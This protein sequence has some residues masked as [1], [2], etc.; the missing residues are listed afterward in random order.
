MFLAQTFDQL[1]DLYDLHRIKSDCRLIQNND[2]RITQNCLC[3]PYSLFIT[4]GKI[5]DQ[6][7]LHGCD[8][9]KLHDFPDLFPSLLFVD[10]LQFCHKCQIFLY[11]HGII[12]RRKLRQIANIPL[13]FFRFLINIMPV[14][15]NFS[16][17]CSQVTG[18]HI[19]RG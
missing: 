8:L 12:N 1:S 6:S 13:G 2:L 19:H 18:Q 14:N 7:I 15:F 3:Q 9:C 11:G 17:G 10:F 5:L 4:F 16:T